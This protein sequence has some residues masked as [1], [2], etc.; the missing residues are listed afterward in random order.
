MVKD[1]RGI[2][3]IGR[4]LEVSLNVRLKEQS[5]GSSSWWSKVVTHLKISR[6]HTSHLLFKK[7]YICACILQLYNFQV[8]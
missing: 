7:M 8:N 6:R 3:E 4:S 2:R 1:M 5:H